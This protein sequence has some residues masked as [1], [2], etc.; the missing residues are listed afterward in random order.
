MPVR[1]VVVIQ[2]IV[3]VL[4][5]GLFPISVWSS[6]VSFQISGF[7]NDRGEV[8]V[9]MYS[10]PQKKLFPKNNKDAFCYQ[11]GLVQKEKTVL[12]CKEVPPGQY[13]AFV[14]HDSNHNGEMD[15]NWMRFP[16]ER[17]GF[18]NDAKVRFGPP[19]F[20]DAVFS[21]DQESVEVLIRIRG[22]F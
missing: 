20:E 11:A 16:E 17:F 8:V 4:L 1:E 21:V 15:H 22:L 9:A 13:A 5:L 12:V 10:T 3:G 18:S 6:E 2:K 7:D 14:Y 19:D